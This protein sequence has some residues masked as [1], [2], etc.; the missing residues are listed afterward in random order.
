MVGAT[1][2]REKFLP[3]SHIFLS[4]A[5]TIVIVG[6]NLCTIRE[7]KLRDRIFFFWIAVFALVTGAF[8]WLLNPTPPTTPSIGGGGYDLSK[9]VYTLSLLAFL[10]LWTVTATVIGL[11]NKNRPSSRRAFLLA[12]VGALT[13]IISFVIYSH[14]IH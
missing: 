12:A 2:N 13:T 8:N 6:L 5:V 4:I 3:I 11:V 1:N 14:N 10:V 7:L 9:P